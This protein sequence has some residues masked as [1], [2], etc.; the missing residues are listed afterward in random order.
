MW[1]TKPVHTEGKTPQINIVHESPGPQGAALLADTPEKVFDLF[2]PDEFILEICFW[3]NQRITILRERYR[4]KRT[5]NDQ[6][7]KIEMRAF[8]GLLLFSAYRKDNHLSTRE[9]FCP[10]KGSLFYRASMSEN[11][12]VFLLTCMRF[13]DINTRE[14]RRETDKFAPV[15]T[16][17]DMLI[18]SCEKYYT[19]GALL[20]IDEQ[21]LGFRG[22]CPFRMYISL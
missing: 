14:E 3:T 8:I 1:K 13:D 15:R 11:R 5:E 4:D 17:W 18:G 10:E 22:K 6:V 16:I 12:F 9:M 2:F 19:P 20:T 7:D 21:L